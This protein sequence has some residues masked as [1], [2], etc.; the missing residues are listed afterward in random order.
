M[1]YPDIANIMFLTFNCVEID[2]VYRMKENV[3]SICYQGKHL[4]FISIVAFPCIGLWVFGI[5][6]FA[7]FVLF[8]NKRV[9]NLME[10]KKITKE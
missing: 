5:P 4:F 1:F 10:L 8:R 2:G 9:L 7:F 3:S 6:L